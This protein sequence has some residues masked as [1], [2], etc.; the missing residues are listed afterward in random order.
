ME[1]LGT[2][3]FGTGTILA[4]CLA[5]FASMGLVHVMRGL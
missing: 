3:D 2:A 1:L 4:F 5:W